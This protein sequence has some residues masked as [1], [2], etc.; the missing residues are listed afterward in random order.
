MTS[1]VLTHQTPVHLFLAV[2]LVLKEGKLALSIILFVFRKEVSLITLRSEPVPRQRGGSDNT[3]TT[4]VFP[5]DPS[6]SPEEPKFEFH[7][8]RE[9]GLQ[10]ARTVPG[11]LPG[12]AACAPEE[13]S[14]L[15]M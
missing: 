6:V 4:W 2:S 10:A 13:T 3:K 8:D 14:Y 1:S 12:A 15:S 11:D 7:G 5:E 9:L